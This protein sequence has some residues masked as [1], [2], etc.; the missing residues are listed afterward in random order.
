MH[1]PFSAPFL[2]PDRSVLTRSGDLVRIRPVRPSDEAALRDMFLRC[3]PE[4]LRL[5]CFGASKTF[6]DVFAARLARVTGGDDFAVAA[7]M[8]SGEIGGVVHAARLPGT[9]AEA[10][11]DIMVRTDLKGRGIGFRLMREMLREAVRSGFRSVHGDVMLGNRA[12]LLLAGDLG[13]RR[14]AM[15]GGVVRISAA[16]RGGDAAAEGTTDPASVLGA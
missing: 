15:E 8:A 4:D 7:V 6:P 16:P 14:V 13:F 10:D 1:T 12:M 5:R 3:S 2:S 9:D 11:Y